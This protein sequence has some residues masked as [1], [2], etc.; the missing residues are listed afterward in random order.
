MTSVPGT[1]KAPC[2][3]C[4]EA[5]EISGRYAHGDH[6]RCGACDTDH[7]ILRGDRIRLVLADV[8]PLRDALA[9]NQQLVN[10]LESDLARARGSFGVGANGF[11]VGVIFAVYR[12]AISGAP[13]SKSLLIGSLAIALVSGLL[14]EAANW[15]FLAKRHA[16]NALTRELGEARADASRLRAQI[17]DA[18]RI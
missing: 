9:Q 1:T 13:I 4:R 5:V 6:I 8:A 11:G 7:K 15:L 16:M 12:V 14:L 17:R 2:V 3:N 10:R 18:T